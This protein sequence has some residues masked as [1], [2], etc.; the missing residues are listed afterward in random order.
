[1]RVYG[2]VP[3]TV[4]FLYQLAVAAGFIAGALMLI[5]ALGLGWAVWLGGISR[6]RDKRDNDRSP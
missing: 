4:A 2:G 3:M 1:M 6:G 5:L